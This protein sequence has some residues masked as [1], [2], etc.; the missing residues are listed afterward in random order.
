M[1]NRAIFNR[2]PLV[3]NFM[4]ALPLGAVKPAGWLREQLEI[5]AKGPTSGTAH[6]AAARATAGSARPIIWTVWFR[7]HTFWRMKS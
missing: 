5:A 4:A 7:W 1:I 3:P 2:A 6:G